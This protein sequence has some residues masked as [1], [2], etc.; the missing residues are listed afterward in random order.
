MIVYKWFVILWNFLNEINLHFKFLD[1]YARVRVYIRPFYT[2][3]EY[4]LH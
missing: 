3:K 4:G 1:I 2:L